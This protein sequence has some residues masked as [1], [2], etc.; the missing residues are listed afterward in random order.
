MLRLAAK[1][2]RRRPPLSSNVRP[3]GHSAGHVLAAAPTAGAGKRCLPRHTG[4]P[5]LA[6]SQ[7]VGGMPAPRYLF[8]PWL[9]PLLS[10]S[11][12]F[13]QSNNA[14]P[15]RISRW[16]YTQSAAPRS[17]LFRGGGASG[18]ACD[19]ER[20]ALVH[21]CR[22]VFFRLAGE[23]NFH[24]SG[25]PPAS[26]LG[27]VA[28]L[29]YA[30]PRGQVAF[31]AS[32]AQLNVRPRTHPKRAV[33]AEFALPRVDEALCLRQSRFASRSVE[34]G[35][36]MQALAIISAVIV[37]TVGAAWLV[38]RF[39]RALP[40]SSSDPRA[41]DEAVLLGVGAGAG[42]AAAA[43]SHASASHGAGACSSDGAC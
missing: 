19:Q 25:Q 41:T 28:L 11:R 20:Q 38:E 6:S 27:R 5:A 36:F 22:Q 31:P 2:A 29:L 37:C 16:R 8:C 26:R 13:S 24:W 43:S 30:A 33:T 10:R 35:V 9:P 42:A 3:R 18:C 17:T 21:R 12:L 4:L 32:A 7:A 34:T 15:N 40:S 39:A 23:P 1:P 14:A